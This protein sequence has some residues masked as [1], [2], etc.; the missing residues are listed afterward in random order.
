[1]TG[2][3]ASPKSII[4]SVKAQSKPFVSPFV[5]TLKFASGLQIFQVSLPW[6]HQLFHLGGGEDHLVVWRPNKRLMQGMLSPSCKKRT[7]ISSQGKFQ[8]TSGSVKKKI[9]LITSPWVTRSVAIKRNL[10]QSFGEKKVSP[11]QEKRG[12]LSPLEDNEGYILEC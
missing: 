9:S 7:P 10:Q 2:V 4:G 12:A 5:G 1:M 8:A 11:S 3:L 6:P